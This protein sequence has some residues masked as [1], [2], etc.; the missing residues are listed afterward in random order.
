MDAGSVLSDSEATATNMTQWQLY[1][2]GQPPHLS[3][4]SELS[5]LSVMSGFVG[6]ISRLY[7]DELTLQL[8]KAAVHLAGRSS[9]QIE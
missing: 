9:S 1:V 3:T 6:C 8:A 2:G 7:V 4:S 5:P